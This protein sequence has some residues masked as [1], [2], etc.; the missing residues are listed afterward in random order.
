MLAT[1]KSYFRN[2]LDGILGTVRAIRVLRCLVTSGEPI[3]QIDVIRETRLAR[4][5]VKNALESLQARGV[6]RKLGPSRAPLYA[7]NDEHYLTA[8]LRALFEVEQARTARLYSAIRALAEGYQPP[9]RGTWLYGSVARGDDI[10]GSDFDLAVVIDA[11]RSEPALERMRD[12]L[13]QLETQSDVSI[14]LMGFN[15]AE[16]CEL[17]GLNPAFWENLKKDAVTLYGSTPEAVAARVRPSA[18][19]QPPSTTDTGHG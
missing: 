12:A 17:P 5:S 1:P 7:L 8:T 6:L 13:Y 3:A 19:Q 10:V 11:E 15:A 16:F 14:S 9:I 4:A 2:P 18:G